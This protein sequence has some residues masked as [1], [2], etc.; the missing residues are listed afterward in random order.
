MTSLPATNPAIDQPWRDQFEP[1]LVELL[2]RKYARQGKRRYVPRN[3]AEVAERLDAFLQAQGETRRARN[4]RRMGG[5]ASKEQFCFDLEGDDGSSELMVLRMDPL[6]GIVETSR[7]REAEVLDAMQG[8]VPAPRIAW[9]DPA[10]AYMGQP[11]MIAHFVGGVTK[12]TSGSGGPSGLGI[13]FDTEVG[14]ALTPQYVGNLAA[15]HRLDFARHHLPSF[16][17]PKPGTEAALWQVNFWSRVLADDGIDASPILNYAQYWLRQNLPVCEKPVLL[18]GDYRLGNFM[19]DEGSLQMTA[20]L[21]WELS[22][23]GDYHEDVSYSLEPLFCS[24][25]TE[26]NYLVSSMMSVD[27]FLHL[28]TEMSGNL[29][30]P[31]TLHWYRVLNSYKL[32]AMNLTSGI[33]AARD[34]TNHQCAFLAFLSASGTAIAATLAKLLTGEIK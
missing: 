11:A 30:D 24:K 7:A 29:I 15:V 22:H 1:F 4:V 13:R 34:G 33:R 18:H 14:E 2:D 28:Y 23:I 26:G 21:D 17:V 20:I 10:G 16:D 12:P 19:Y 5:G 8:I 27:R 9:V 32:A 6:E 3:A 31:A 25:D